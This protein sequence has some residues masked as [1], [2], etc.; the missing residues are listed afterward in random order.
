MR[1][2]FF[3]FFICVFYAMHA[4]AQQIIIDNVIPNVWF[5]EVTFMVVLNNTTNNDTIDASITATGLNVP[6]HWYG[7]TGYIHVVGLPLN[8]ADHNGMLI[9]KNTA[10][11]SATLWINIQ[12]Q[13]VSHLNPMVSPVT[14]ANANQTSFTA[15]GDIFGKDTS[16]W[17]R[18]EV[19]ADTNTISIQPTP[20]WQSPLANYLQAENVHPVDIIDLSGLNPGMYYLRLRAQNVWF[21]ELSNDAIAF[22]VGGQPNGVV[23]LL[24][25]GGY[26]TIE[27]GH[28][29][30]NLPEKVPVMVYSLVGDLVYTS[31]S[32]FKHDINTNFLPAGCYLL[33][34]GNSSYKFTK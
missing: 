18:W 2:L 22:W 32:A 9:V 33:K 10:G 5:Q 28:L 15:M 30:V 34:G 25:G 11:D 14:I 8:Y 31:P 29:T 16:G 17:Y 21:D 27:S 13:N 6:A 3:T 24:K 4:N 12:V 26:L 7:D 19:Y 23:T 1:K 20:V